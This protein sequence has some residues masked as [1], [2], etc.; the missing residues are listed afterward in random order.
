MELKA[1]NAVCDLCWLV[2]VR[3]IDGCR[4]P[5]VYPKPRSVVVLA[6]N[7]LRSL[8]RHKV[9]VFVHTDS[10]QAEVCDSKATVKQGLFLWLNQ[11]RS[12]NR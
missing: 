11:S 9:F 1:S 6:N 4:G 7:P 12:L 5:V 8:R 3:E 2:D 10:H